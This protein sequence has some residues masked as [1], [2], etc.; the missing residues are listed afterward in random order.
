[1]ATATATVTPPL[2]PSQQAAR[3]FWRQAGADGM[4]PFYVMS[5]YYGQLSENSESLD[6][7][8]QTLEQL[9]TGLGYE[10]DVDTVFDELNAGQ[11]EEL[12]YWAGRYCL[13]DSAGNR[14][15]LVVGRNGATLTVPPALVDVTSLPAGSDL[16]SVTVLSGAGFSA[17]ELQLQNAQFQ[18]SLRFTLPVSDASL[19]AGS[20]A[21]QAT[22]PTCQG[23][24]GPKG[25]GAAGSRAVNGKRGAWTQAGVDQAADGD[26]ASAWYGQY[27]LLDVTDVTAVTQD[28]DPVYIYNDPQSGLTFQ[29][30][31]GNNAKYSGNVTYNNN[32]LQCPD[33]YD[34]TTNYAMQFI[35]PQVGAAEINLAVTTAGVVGSYRG[36][37]IGRYQ[38]ESPAPQARLAKRPMT[39]VYTPGSG[40]SGGGYSQ[41]IDLS[42]LTPGAPNKIALPYG[43]VDNTYAL[44]LNLTDSSTGS[45]PTGTFSWTLS[46]DPTGRA[47]I[48]SSGATAAQF[49][50]VN[51]SD[52]DVGRQ[53]L[54]TV[55]LTDNSA[56][57]SVTYTLLFD[58]Q[59]IKFYASLAPTALMPAVVGTPYTQN[60]V[61]HGASDN[62]TWSVTR[63]LPPGLTW[64][65]RNHQLSGTV[66]DASQVGKA[67][68]LVVELTASDVIMDPLTFSLGI[69]VQ[70]APAVAS[71]MPPSEQIDIWSIAAS[72][73]VIAAL[74][75]YAYNRYKAAKA[76]P[77]TADAV[78]KANTNVQNATGGDPKSISQSI[79]QTDNTTLPT[80]E[81]NIP[82]RQSLLND[83]D[84]QVKELS[85]QI[86]KNEATISKLQE[87]LQE[88]KR[89]NWDDPV[90]DEELVQAGYETYGDAG[91][92]LQD[93]RQLNNAQMEEISAAA[94]RSNQETTKTASDQTRVSEANIGKPNNQS[95]LLEE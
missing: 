74:A 78:N 27:V 92:G 51:L 32:V 54:V 1:M 37:W 7:V 12:G 2:T 8:T 15:D 29:W 33:E 40:A 58:I 79:V 31:D 85:T 77:K 16:A 6:V 5:Q 88:H 60:L 75:A 46:N 44:S 52:S 22:A 20:A 81:G 21:F 25:G 9:L 83:I 43:A 38:P 13:F 3:E 69:T 73:L 28:P 19:D 50:L 10:T 62:F 23:T 45:A 70:S 67:F 59:V 39:A 17:G 41:A 53:L 11:G 56:A 95:L 47:A 26:P 55:Q 89:D 61:A 48:A 80:V 36:Y 4:P 63:S 84:R 18:V 64:D 65:D 35:A 49:T 14:F 34:N 90:T 72:G 82:V 68:G 71:D 87:Y 42:S 76:N 30:G 93:L 24:F 66:T 86:A 91:R 57:P 94:Q